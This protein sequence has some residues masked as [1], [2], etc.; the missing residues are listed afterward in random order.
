MVVLS[1]AT[2]VRT[3]DLSRN[4]LPKIPPALGRFTELKQLN[5]ERNEIGL[6]I[7]K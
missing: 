7:E 2:T 5:A 1:L 4:R 3:I 6:S